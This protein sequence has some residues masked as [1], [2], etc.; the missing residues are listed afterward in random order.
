MHVL[1]IEDN[2]AVADMIRLVLEGRGLN[3]TAA[4]YGE[5]G[6]DLAKSYTYDII[7]LDLHLPDECVAVANALGVIGEAAILR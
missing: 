1:L 5:D 2:K 7:I 3:L 6:I 4:E